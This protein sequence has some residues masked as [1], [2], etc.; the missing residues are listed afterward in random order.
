MC[1]EHLREVNCRPRFLS[2]AIQT[3]RVSLWPQIWL[4]HICVAG[5][6]VFPEGSVTR[7]MQTFT[8]CLSPDLVA[9]FSV[10]L[11]RFCALKAPPNSMNLFYCSYMFDYFQ[12]MACFI[13]SLTPPP[14]THTKVGSRKSSFKRVMV[15]KLEH[16]E[17][18]EVHD[19]RCGGVQWRT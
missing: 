10:C 13:L 11:S 1:C 18:S 8:R 15:L 14:H 4:H 5:V 7:G 3:G 12:P 19:S 17:G 16:P 2:F 6:P 9:V